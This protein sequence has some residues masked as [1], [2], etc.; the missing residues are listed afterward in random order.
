MVG[1]D[2]VEFMQELGRL[3]LTCYPEAN[4]NVVIVNSFRFEEAELPEWLE[5]GKY[6][7]AVIG[8]LSE[9]IRS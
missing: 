7:R 3:G 4:A 9:A 1:A 6:Q 8:W 2:A 5:V